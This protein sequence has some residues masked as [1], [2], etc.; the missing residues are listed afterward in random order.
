MSE[1]SIKAKV[2]GNYTL[3]PPGNKIAN[4][5]AMIQVGTVLESFQGRTPEEAQKLMLGFEIT[6]EKHIFDEAKGPEPFVI[7]VEHLLSLHKKANLRKMVESWAGQSYTDKEMEEFE[8]T[9]L[10]GAPC[11]ANII[12]DKNTKGEER[13]KIA[14]VTAVPDGVTP[15]TMINKPLIFVYKTPFDTETFNRIPE[16]IQK[17]MKT[18]NEYK[19]ALEGG[20]V[21]ETKTTEQATTEFQE[22]KGGFPFKKKPL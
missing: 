6:T 3:C 19:Q 12:A 13:R 5:F 2:G 7:W 8:L 1:N 21:A 17:K 16:W 22:K 10:V 14:N 9:E 20:A 15:A 11:M 4:C 18:S